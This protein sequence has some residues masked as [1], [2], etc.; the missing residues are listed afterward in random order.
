MVGNI[1]DVEFGSMEWEFL[2]G[3]DI[4]AYASC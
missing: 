4:E 1:A 2:K 3:K